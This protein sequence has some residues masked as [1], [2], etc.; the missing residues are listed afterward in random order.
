MKVDKLSQTEHLE[1][2][3]SKSGVVQEEEELDVYTEQR[4]K[5][6]IQKFMVIR[7]N[8]LSCQDCG[9]SGHRCWS[10]KVK[11]N[12]NKCN[13]EKDNFKMKIWEGH[14]PTLLKNRQIH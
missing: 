2:K 10:T 11:G 5:P 4:H 13:H 6:W 12:L 9:I 14:T 7:V 8:N 1:D 3:H